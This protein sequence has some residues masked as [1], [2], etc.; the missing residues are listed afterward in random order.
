LGVE[1]G[2]EF[3]RVYRLPLDPGDGDGNARE[4]IKA[5]P[6]IHMMAPPRWMSLKIVALVDPTGPDIAYIG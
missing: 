6:P 3:A 5:S 2:V 1:D 4:N